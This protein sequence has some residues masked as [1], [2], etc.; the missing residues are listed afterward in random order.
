[1]G[2]S[3]EEI[4]SAF[5]QPFSTDDVDWR[6]TATTKD[7][8]RGIAAPYVK[9]R[10]IQSRLDAVVGPYHWKPEYM[11][12]HTVEGKGSQLCGIAIYIEERGEWLQKW[13]GAENTDVEPVK[14][15]ISDAFKRAA[16]TWGIGRYLYDIPKMWVNVEPKGSSYVIKDDA[17]P[18]LIAHYEKHAGVP[19]SNVSR[20]PKGTQ[21][22]K[23]PEKADAPP[24]GFDYSISQVQPMEF[25]SGKGMVMRLKTPDGKKNFEVFLQRADDQLSPGICLKNVKLSPFQ[26][27]GKKYHIIDAYEVA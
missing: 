22:S 15:G 19:P 12:W 14:G 24:P 16:V 5:A 3:P 18:G 17:M 13:D 27:E 2:K 4:M 11:L 26:S 21:G 7:K 9:S 25:S 1:M 10:A 23:A 8:S 20:F 6:I